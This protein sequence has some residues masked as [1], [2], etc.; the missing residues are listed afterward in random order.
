MGAHHLIGLLAL[1]SAQGLDLENFS[2]AK[3]GPLL[4]LMGFVATS[5]ISICVPFGA[6]QKRMPVTMHTLVYIAYR[7]FRNPT[8]PRVKHSGQH[9]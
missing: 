8:G 9:I 5:T 4:I 1:I 3:A 7:V 2:L 6:L